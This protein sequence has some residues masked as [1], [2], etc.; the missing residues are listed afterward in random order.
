VFV[1][2]VQG[3]NCGYLATLGGLT[4]GSIVVYSQESGISLGK[5][6]EDIKFLKHR[7]TKEEAHGI[8]SEGRLIVRADSSSIAYKYFIINY[9]H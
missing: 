4:T 6:S 9:Q 2:E 1:V 3:G 7:Y 5:L 8:P